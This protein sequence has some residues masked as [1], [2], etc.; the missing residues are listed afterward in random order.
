ML[1]VQGI[2]LSQHFY[3][4][5]TMGAVELC[6]KIWGPRQNQVLT[7]AK[8]LNLI[9]TLEGSTVSLP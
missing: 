4:L 3:D 8:P 9:L 2:W 6:V 1:G 7:T 5:P